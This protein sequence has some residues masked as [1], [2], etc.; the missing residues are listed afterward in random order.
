MTKQ[1]HTTT[2][3]F[4]IQPAR[5]HVIAT[6][7]GQVFWVKASIQEESGRESVGQLLY[8]QPRTDDSIES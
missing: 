6:V 5:A 7:F 8:Q 3:E 4:S 1:V 2:T